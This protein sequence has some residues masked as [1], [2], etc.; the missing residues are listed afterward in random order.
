MRRGARLRALCLVLM[1]LLAGAAIAEDSLPETG[2]DEDFRPFAPPPSWTSGP[3]PELAIPS[4]LAP[5]I[6]R[7]A[8]VAERAERDGLARPPIAASAIRRGL[9]AAARPG[10]EGAVGFTVRPS[11]LSLSTALVS[12]DGSWR[13][14]ATRFDWSL[15][16]ARDGSQDGLDWEAATGGGLGFAGS[17]EQRASATLGYRHHLFDHVT[18]ISQVAL[19]TR[20]EFAADNLAEANLVPELRVVAD[21]TQPMA[22]PWKTVIDVKLGRRIPLS[23]T[24]FETTGSAMLRLDWR[25]P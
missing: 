22:T 14:D 24:G 2:P 10:T 6:D 3:Y 11:H 8:A 18:L 25:A 19:A 13:A 9:G 7:R 5:G 16:R 12:G 21:L 23:G 17:G 15:A 1:P 20:Y 4:F